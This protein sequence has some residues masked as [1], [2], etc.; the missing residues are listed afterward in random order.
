MEIEFDINSVDKMPE[1]KYEC[2]YI[3]SSQFNNKLIFI[4]Q[5]KR[6]NISIEY[7]F[8]MIWNGWQLTVYLYYIEI[9]CVYVS[10]RIVHNK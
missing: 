2:K 1:H 8:S 5:I 7:N 9:K 4:S 6:N 10:Y 3:E